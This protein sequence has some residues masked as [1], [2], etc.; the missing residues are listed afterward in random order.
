M[1]DLD[2]N[3]MELIDLIVQFIS[4]IFVIGVLALGIIKYHDFT[5][6]KNYVDYRIKLQVK[7]NERAK[8][9]QTY[10]LKKLELK[11]ARKSIH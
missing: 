2:L 3:L 7:W 1:T 5:T 8:Q 10:R 4:M 9:F 6:S 11:N